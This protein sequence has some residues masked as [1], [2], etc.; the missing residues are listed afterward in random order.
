LSSFNNSNRPTFQDMF[1]HIQFFVSNLCL[2]FKL[3]ND[4]VFL[5]LIIHNFLKNER[6]ED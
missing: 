2:Y 4:Q 3:L 6:V 5:K 1:D